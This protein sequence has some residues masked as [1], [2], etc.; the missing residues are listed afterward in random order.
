MQRKA[1]AATSRRLELLFH[2]STNGA[3]LHSIAATFFV[4]PPNLPLSFLCFLAFFRKI[5]S[6]LGH[7]LRLTS[8]AGGNARMSLKNS[9]DVSTMLV[10]VR[11]GDTSLLGSVLQH[12]QSYLHL[13]ARLK[14]DEDLQS[15]FD[16]A[17]V[18]QDSFLD[19]HRDF[20]KFRGTSEAELMQWLRKILAAN[21][22][23][24]VRHY[25]G[26]QK[27]DVRLERQFVNDLDHS[28]SQLRAAA[29]V[30]DDT[31]P[32]VRAT[33]REEI[34]RVADALERLRADYRD[35]L[36][37]RHLKGLSFPEI[38]DR[39]GRSVGSVQKLWMRALPQIREAMGVES[40]G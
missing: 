18:V 3:H 25:R 30:S 24:Q 28:S 27:R 40:N 22:V 39:M 10:R 5:T 4:S 21:I 15:K 31:S 6:V 7:S 35:V 1:V 38:A 29:F 36:I 11:T 17:D 9:L 13:L 2:R 32:S 16:P 20:H 19:A 34:A 14:L 8:L 12:Y 26:I 23:D 37:F 33:N